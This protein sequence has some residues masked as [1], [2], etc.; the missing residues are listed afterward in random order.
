MV[1]SLWLVSNCVKFAWA[2]IF[3]WWQNLTYNLHET[4]NEELRLKLS[5]TQHFQDILFEGMKGLFSFWTPI[6]EMQLQLF[7]RSDLIGYCRYKCTTAHP[8]LSLTPYISKNF[9][10]LTSNAF[11]QYSMLIIEKKENVNDILLLDT[12]F[13]TSL[14]FMFFVEHPFL[15][16]LGWFK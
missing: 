11:L 7:M 2:N 12:C 15:H 13:V 6:L 8:T 4:S 9:K 16:C 1:C 3:F 14:V 10:R 5:K